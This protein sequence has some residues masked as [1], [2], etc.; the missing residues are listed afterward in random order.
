MEGTE[1]MAYC[2]LGIFGVNMPLSYGEGKGAF[3]RLREE[4]IPTYADL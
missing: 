4:I 1:D 2:S 3:L